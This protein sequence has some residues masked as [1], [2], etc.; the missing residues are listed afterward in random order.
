[1]DYERVH[2]EIGIA[3]LNVLF[4][5][6]IIANG[7]QCTWANPTWE[8]YLN[9]RDPQEQATGEIDRIRAAMRRIRSDG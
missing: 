7:G 6:W 1:M 5:Q 9:R 8:S 4:H 2:D 3:E